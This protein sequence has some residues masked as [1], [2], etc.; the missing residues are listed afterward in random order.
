MQVNNLQKRKNNNIA[1][2]TALSNIINPFEKGKVALTSTPTLVVKVADGDF[3]YFIHYLEKFL[4]CKM[5]GTSNNGK[6][7]VFNGDLKITVK[8]VS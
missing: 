2:I 5:A 6:V 4:P 8:T 7:A 1:A 3:N